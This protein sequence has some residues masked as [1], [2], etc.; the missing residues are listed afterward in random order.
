MP[1]LGAPEVVLL[2]L[3]ALLLF[4]SEEMIRFAR[5]LGHLARMLRTLWLQS[6]A[7]MD[8]LVREV[9]ADEAAPADAAPADH[10]EE[11]QEQGPWLIA[12]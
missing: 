10:H 4:G 7:Q 5:R 8:D 9:I 11:N 6:V 1:N 12:S 3:L 2:L